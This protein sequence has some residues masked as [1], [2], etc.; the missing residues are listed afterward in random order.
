MK[1]VLSEDEGSVLSEGEGPVLSEDEGFRLEGPMA[2]ANIGNIRLISSEA[3]S[4]AFNMHEETAPYRLPPAAACFTGPQLPHNEST[5]ARRRTLGLTASFPSL[6]A[7][8]AWHGRFGLA[9]ILPR[10]RLCRSA[11]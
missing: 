1:P 8:H 3:V 6:Y 11:P 7:S 9:I 5:V 2:S 10:K 4:N